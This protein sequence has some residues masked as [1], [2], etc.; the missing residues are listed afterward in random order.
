MKNWE[1]SSESAI[2]YF[3]M[4]ALTAAFLLYGICYNNYY[5][6]YNYYRIYYTIINIYYTIIIA[7]IIILISA[8]SLIPF[9]RL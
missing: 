9:N 6:L 3:L 4:G 2:K 1:L 5:L 8:L 7:V